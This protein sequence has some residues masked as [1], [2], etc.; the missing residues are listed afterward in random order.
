[1]M[2]L[3]EAANSH[4]L[5]HV[6]PTS[7]SARDWPAADNLVSQ[8]RTLLKETNRHIYKPYAQSNLIF[9]KVKILSIHTHT[10]ART[11]THILMRWTAAERA[12]VFSFTNP[13]YKKRLRLDRDS[14]SFFFLPD[15]FASKTRERISVIQNYVC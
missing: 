15:T 12:Q 2:E 9:C 7:R 13:L 8:S 10:H 11:R 1:M 5:R 14:L 4:W 3:T 6:A